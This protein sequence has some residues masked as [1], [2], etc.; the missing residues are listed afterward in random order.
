MTP[1]VPAVITAGGRISGEFS[2]ATG[3][4]IKA[5]V[6]IEGRLMVE[7]VLD[8]LRESGRV[9]EPVIVVGPREALKAA[10]TLPDEGGK[11]GGDVRLI[12]EG[13]TG[14]E[15]MVRGL[16]A[17]P[18]SGAQGW[19][20]LCTCDVPFLTGESISWLLDNAPEDADIVFPIVTREEYEAAFPGTPGTYA[21]VERKQYTGGSV[22]LVRPSVIFQNK[23]L[24]ERIFAARKDIIS[25]ARL[26]GFGL[27][28]RLFTGT[29]TVEY[30]EARA[31]RLTGCRCRALR[32]APPSL[33][34][35]VDTME[36]Y[37]YAC[38]HIAGQGA[39]A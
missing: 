11:N 34:A 35:D 38:G 8:A 19:A 4:A 24:I 14:P 13:A 1:S 15:N 21:P 9:A 39:R 7:R 27:L 28:W 36:D 6:T 29:L 26:G 30:V 32:N 20:L 33:A 22:L 16:S 2:S 12:D 23:A 37:R 18:E 17:I 5:T 3:T 25:M 10:L 31:S